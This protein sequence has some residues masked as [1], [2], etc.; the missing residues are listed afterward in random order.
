[1]D[2]L[3]QRGSKVEVV[4]MDRSHSFK[5]TV[6]EALGRPII[7]TDCFHFSRYIYWALERVRIRVQ[8]D[9][10]EYDR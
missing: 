7:V 1:M 10:D 8:R 3:N 4:V 5:A 2:Y 9:F 6:N